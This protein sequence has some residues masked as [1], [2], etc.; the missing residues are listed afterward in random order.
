[1]R[2]KIVCERVRR[3]VVRDRRRTTVSRRA[4]SRW[5]DDVQRAADVELACGEL[6]VFVLTRATKPVPTGSTCAVASRDA[7]DDASAHLCLSCNGGTRTVNVPGSSDRR[8]RDGRFRGQ[9]R[10]HQRGRRCGAR[11]RVAATGR[12]RQRDVSPP[13]QRSAVHREPVGVGVD[14]GARGLRAPHSSRRRPPPPAEWFERIGRRLPRAVVDTRRARAVGRRRDGHAS[15]PPG[16]TARPRL[17]SRSVSRAPVPSR[18]SPDVGGA[19]VQRHEHEM[20]GPARRV[21]GTLC[22]QSIWQRPP[23]TRRSPEPGPDVARPCPP[24]LGP[25]QERRG[26]RPSVRIAMRVSSS[27]RSSLSLCQATLSLPSR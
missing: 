3:H 25:D 18:A 20:R 14:R 12:H 15:P 22:S 9:A 27:S 24:P 8:A 2:A 26:A 10:S 23:I 7:R 19:G 4:R 1:M 16:R 5:H 21:F 6:Q 13:G 11:I 17:R